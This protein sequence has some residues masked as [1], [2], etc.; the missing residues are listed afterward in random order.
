[1]MA[2]ID[3]IEA[4]VPVHVDPMR[5]AQLTFRP[6]D[7]AAQNAGQYSLTRIVL[8]VPA[9]TAAPEDERGLR[10]LNAGRRNGL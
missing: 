2:G 8:A 7:A 5:P 1:M 9:Q 10:T 3:H 6:F 4:S